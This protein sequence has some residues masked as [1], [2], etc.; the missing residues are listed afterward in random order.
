MTRLPR[1]LES[2]FLVASGELGFCS[3]AWLFL[4]EL[5]ANGAAGGA[6][7]DVQGH[8]AASG[9][10]HDGRHCLGGGGDTG[11]YLGL[12]A[13]ESAVDAQPVGE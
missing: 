10:F 12:G 9:A 2:A 13:G 1:A 7:G 5:S 4:R 8:L 6:G 11:Q 3:A